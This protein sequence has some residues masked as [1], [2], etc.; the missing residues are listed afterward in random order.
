MGQD[1]TRKTIFDNYLKTVAPL[2]IEY[3]NLMNAFPTGVL[4]EIRDV[5]F[6]LAKSESLTEVD[7]Q[8]RELKKADRHMTRAMRDCYKYICIAYESFYKNYSEKCKYLLR[9]IKI[10]Q[11]KC[12]AVE[13]E[14]QHI[15]ALAD[16]DYARELEVS[17]ESDD[18]DDKIY[19][20]YEKAK[21]SYEVLCSKIKDFYFKNNRNT[22]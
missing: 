11:E 12:K 8:K 9:K 16:I 21:A 17:L 20:A 14:Q 15:I 22:D 6:H 4:N 13:I 18:I 5:M 7:L 19:M 2:V 3:E 10:E 1:V